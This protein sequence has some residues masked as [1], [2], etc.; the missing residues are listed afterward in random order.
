MPSSQSHN[1]VG[2]SCPHANSPTQWRGDSS[3]LAYRA[4]V[5]RDSGNRRKS[6]SRSTM[7]PKPPLPDNPNHH[8]SNI[9]T[10]KE[11]IYLKYRVWHLRRQRNLIRKSLIWRSLLRHSRIRLG[12]PSSRI[13]S[14][15]RVRDVAA[16][17]TF[18]RFPSRR[19]RGTSANCVKPN[20]SKPNPVAAKSITS[21][22]WSGSN[23][24]ATPSALPSIHQVA[25]KSILSCVVPS[26]L[27][28]LIPILSNVSRP[29]AP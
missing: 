10:C 20:S 19:A 12:S 1:R 26:H 7:P 11:I 25:E 27:H 2:A 17:S 5:P 22:K 6:R 28:A 13:Y 29:L 8:F 3:Q 15:T 16:W 4:F 21:S 24:F 18:S 14:I 23:I 9:P